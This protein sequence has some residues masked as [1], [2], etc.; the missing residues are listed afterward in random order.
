VPYDE[1]PVGGVPEQRL[2]RYFQSLGVP[3]TAYEAQNPAA[4]QRAVADM[5]HLERWPLRTVE[6][7]PSKDGSRYAYALSLLMIAVLISAKLFEVKIWR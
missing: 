4:L 1:L 5:D 7:L 3:Y 6:L 2:H